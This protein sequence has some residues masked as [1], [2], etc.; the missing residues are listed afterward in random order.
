[1]NEFVILT[2]SS[3]DLPGDLARKLELEV[4]YLSVL[5]EGNTYQNDLDEK[6]ITNKAT[7]QLF[8]EG[9]ASKTSAASVGQFEEVMEPLL[10][11][12]KDLLYIGFSSGL[13]GT[14]NAGQIA[15]QELSEKYPER[16]VYTVDTLCASL[17]Q[18]MMVYLAAQERFKGKTI[19]EVRDFVEENKLKL[20]H[21]FT[22]DDLNFLYR[23]GR[24][25]KTTAVIGSMLSMKPIMHVD[26][27]GKLVKV[28]VARGRKAS[29]NAMFDKMKQTAINPEHQVIFISHGDCLEDA[30]LLAQKVKDAWNVPEVIINYVG[31]VI[32]SHSGPGTLAL[33]FLATE[34]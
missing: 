14:Y 29:I 6:S 32:G 30:K 21:W 27:A 15:A 24:V 10:Q 25:S 1:M 20:A 17:G 22:V 31:P 8:R 3:C 18:G 2:D 9:K 19:E 12:G 34:R 5:I 13:S 16:K 23:G 4:I 33:F 26:N 7:Y 11:A 28:S